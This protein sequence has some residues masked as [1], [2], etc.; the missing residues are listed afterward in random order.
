MP[1]SFVSIRRIK[2]DP[3]LSFTWALFLFFPRIW[4]PG[5]TLL[6]VFSVKG[7][8][9]LWRWQDPQAARFLSLICVPKALFPSFIFQQP[10]PPFLFV[11]PFFSFTNEDCT[12]STFAFALLLDRNE[13]T[14]I[15]CLYMDLISCCNSQ[16]PKRDFDLFQICSSKGSNIEFF[17]NPNAGESFR[18][19]LQNLRWNEKGGIRSGRREERVEE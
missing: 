19:R 14:K 8:G 2:H 18:W 13:D 9:L 6:C 10:N 11:F 7:G 3:A 5:T 15:T 12:F 17:L 16:G 1:F 4:E